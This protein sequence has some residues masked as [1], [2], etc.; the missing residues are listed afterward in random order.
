MCTA[1]LIDWDPATP[2]PPA[3]GLIYKGA[4]GQS[5]E[6][7]SLCNPLVADQQCLDADQIHPVLLRFQIFVL[8]FFCYERGKKTTGWKDW[9]LF[10]T[11]LRFK[12][13]PRTQIP[14]AVIGNLDLG[15]W[16]G[17]WKILRIRISTSCKTAK[18]KSTAVTPYHEVHI[19]LEYGTIASVPSSDLGP[20]TPAPASESV[21]P[22]EPRAF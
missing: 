15:K 7:A 8:P 9:G 6:T 4:I 10:S 13:M 22:P 17:Y 16:S 2:P 12:A 14:K 18:Y 3:F 5:R 21:P 11:N 20:H 19:V 1:V